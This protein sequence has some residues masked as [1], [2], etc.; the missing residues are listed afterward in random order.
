MSGK[1]SFVDLNHQHAE[2]RSELDAA[3]AGIIDRSAF[4]GGE[5][6][7]RFENEFAAYLGVKEVIGTSNGTDALWLALASVGVEAGDLVVTVPNTFIATVEAITRAGAMPLFV[8]IEPD[9]C[10]MDMQALKRLLEDECILLDDL[11][12]IHKET[13]RRVAAFLPVHLYGLPV[14]LGALMTLSS[15]YGI[16]VV[17]D[18]CQAHGSEVL[19]NGTWHKAGTLG[20]ASAFSFYPGKNLGAMGDAGAAATN[21]PEAARMMRILREHGSSQKY[22]HPTANGWNSRLDSIQ[23]AILSVKLKHLDTWNDRRIEAANFYRQT[24]TGTGLQL[25]ADPVDRKQNYHLFVVHTPDRDRFRYELSVRG[26]DS[27]IHYP[28]ALHLQKAYQWLNLPAGSFPNAERSAACCLSLPMHQ[29]LTS[30]QIEEIGTAVREIMGQ[31]DAVA[32]PLEE[33]KKWN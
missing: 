18:A 25:P 7:T 27:G 4:I 29:N 20:A 12:L 1:I 17:E 33:A 6:V 14:D 13:Q 28:I 26:I 19:L 31:S 22:I 11:R 32:V 3:I 2:I 10:L 16:P 9:T 21:D 15:Q 30:E 8:D 5:T 23:A 24:L